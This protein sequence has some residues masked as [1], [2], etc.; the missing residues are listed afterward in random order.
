MPDESKDSKR[1]SLFK[2]IGRGPAVDSKAESISTIG[3]DDTAVPPPPYKADGQSAPDGADGAEAAN[4]TA[5]FDKLNLT[6]LP[7]DPSVETCLAHLKLLF[8]IQWMKEDVGFTDG[9][10]GLWDAHAGPVNPLLKK[11]SEKGVKEKA[12]PEPTLEERR[13]DKN[14]ETLSRIREKRWAVFVAR[15][16][17]RYEAWWKWLASQQSA[18][19][20]SVADIDTGLDGYL[21]FPVDV[22][23]VM[24]WTEDLL[25]P[26]DVLMVWHTH[27]L[28]P[29][30]F[31]EDAMLAG[32]RRVWV[33]GMPWDL[34]NKAIDADF[35]YNVSP[36]CKAHWEQHTGR[37]WDNAGDKLV[38]ALN[39]PRCTALASI[40]WT[41]CARAE[42][43]QVNE[44]PV[45]TGTGYGD[46]DLSHT[47]EAC[48]AVITRRLLSVAKF[49]EDHKALLGPRNRP[50]PGTVLD[51]KEGKPKGPALP[52]G[53]KLPAA[54]TFPDRLLT[55]GCNM[56]RST[57]ADMIRVS[58]DVTMDDVRF[59]IEGVLKDRD[60]VR[61]IE[62]VG[63]RGRYALPE[64]SRIAVRKMMSRYWDNHSAF[65]LELGGAVLRQGLFV[66]K[67]CQLDWLHSPSARDTMTRLLTKYARFVEIMR[68]KPGNV[69]VPT[70][71]VDLAWHTHQL[72]PARYYRY[73][74]ELTGKFIDHDDKIDE[75]TLSA[76]FEWTSKTY[77]E[78]YGEVY[79]ACTCWYCECKSARTQ[80]SRHCR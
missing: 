76:Q 24:A 23:R 7:V 63:S 61:T 31:L 13:N 34:V 32:I 28:N 49:I 75:G 21:N 35:N 47:C 80:A 11:R 20:V 45:L 71:D 33:S 5:A 66:E 2:R 29:R 74:V 62:G 27:M 73:T 1:A 6:N 67:M 70:L 3:S 60:H 59:V 9:L 22:E 48:G 17:D 54:Q 69:V 10:W 15:A 58:A 14:L 72:S 37:A 18:Q 30:A 25:P 68:R 57:I 42:D 52:A 53:L 38:K 51:P 16:V 44:P 39:C 77:Q 4:L 50:M 40:P 65:A 41:T 26:L 46:S 19:P 36:T 43:D 55:S 8:A 56:V 64:A 12:E 78:L 79:S